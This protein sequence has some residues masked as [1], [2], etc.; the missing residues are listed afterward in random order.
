MV[1]NTCIW[2]CRKGETFPSFEAYANEGGSVSG[3]LNL[4]PLFR[5]SLFH[6][7]KH[8]AKKVAPHILVTA[9]QVGQD[10]MKRNKKIKNVAKKAMSRTARTLG[11]STRQTLEDELARQATQK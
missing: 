2:R 8:V 1:H 11:R 5:K 10:I 3:S 6:M 9:L 4:S 7:G